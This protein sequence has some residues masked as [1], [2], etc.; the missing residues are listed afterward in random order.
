LALSER[1][2]YLNDS[3]APPPIAMAE[4]IEKRIK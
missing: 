1:T 3:R 4:R 2:V